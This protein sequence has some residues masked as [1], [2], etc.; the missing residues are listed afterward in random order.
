[1]RRLQKNACCKKSGDGLLKLHEKHVIWLVLDAVL[2]HIPGFFT[3]GK[4][5]GM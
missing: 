4:N 2:I 3:G 5:V 1:M